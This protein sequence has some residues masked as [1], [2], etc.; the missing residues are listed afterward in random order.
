[1]PFALGPPGGRSPGFKKMGVFV[2][3][4]EGE[5]LERLKSLVLSKLGFPEKK[6]KIPVNG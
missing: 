5:A 6:K 4:G 3:E 2:V 1:M